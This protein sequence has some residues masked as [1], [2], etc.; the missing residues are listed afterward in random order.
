LRAGI[1]LGI[2]YPR[3][4]VDL[5]ETRKRALDAYKGMREI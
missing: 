1:T 4:I 2:Q 5:K 3:A